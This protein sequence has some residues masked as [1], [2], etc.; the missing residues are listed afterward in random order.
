MSDKLRVAMEIVVSH[1]D[2]I[3]KTIF[4]KGEGM[5]LTFIARKP[6]NHESDMLITSETDLDDLIALLERSKERKNYGG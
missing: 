3:E 2:Q 5:K 1:L 4:K 6:G